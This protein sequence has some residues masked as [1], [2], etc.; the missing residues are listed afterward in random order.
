MGPGRVQTPHLIPTSPLR[1]E[2]HLAEGCI[3]FANQR[4]SCCPL[5]EGLPIAN[6]PLR[7]SV[8][9]RAPSFPQAAGKKVA[10]QSTLADMPSLVVGWGRAGPHTTKQGHNGKFVQERIA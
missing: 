7:V 9:H 1:M 3:R 8:P 5:R 6:C 2:N 4:K 10:A